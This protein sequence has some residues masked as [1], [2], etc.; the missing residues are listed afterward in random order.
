MGSHFKDYE[1]RVFPKTTFEI[2]EATS[3]YSKKEIEAI[4]DSGMLGL[5]SIYLKHLMNLNF[6]GNVLLKVTIAKSGKVIDVDIMSSS[7]ENTKFDEAVKN[8]VAAWKW[9][10]KN[11]SATVTILYKFATIPPTNKAGTRAFLINGVRPFNDIFSNLNR[12]SSG[13]AKIQNKYLK[14]KPDLDDRIIVIFKF[15]VAKSGY[16]TDVDIVASTA[17]Y[18]EFE[19]AIKSFVATWKFKPIENGNTT[20]SI[21]L[22]FYKPEPNSSSSGGQTE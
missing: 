6:E 2:Q 21:F 12:H 4:V 15:E 17:E 22:T 5:R 11:D 7:T 14:L 1:L 19:E 18:A 10:V 13:L 9:N 8:K 3:S 16:V 20:V